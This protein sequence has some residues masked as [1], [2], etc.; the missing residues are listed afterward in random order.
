MARVW[1]R[2]AFFLPFRN[3]SPSPIPLVPFFCRTRI[4]GG[5]GMNHVAEAAVLEAAALVA[6]MQ[7]LEAVRDSN[8]HGGWPSRSSSSSSN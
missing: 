6:Q 7:Q 4:F 1:R 5:Y 8:W 3:Y 2:L